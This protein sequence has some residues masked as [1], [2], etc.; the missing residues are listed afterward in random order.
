MEEW[1]CFRKFG[2]G[3]GCYEHEGHKL[4]VGYFYPTLWRKLPII[5][6]NLRPMVVGGNVEH[7]RKNSDNLIS[8]IT[9][10]NNAPDVVIAS[11]LPNCMSQ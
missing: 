5:R 2:D 8:F 4:N 9:G 10:S 3:E 6:D 11:E 7:E 1:S